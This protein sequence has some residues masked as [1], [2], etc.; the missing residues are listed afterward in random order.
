MYGVRLPF[1]VYPSTSQLEGDIL[2]AKQDYAGAFASYDK[3]NQTELASPASFFSAAKAKELS[4]AAPEE[5]IAL[6]DSCIAR[7]QTPITFRFGSLPVGT[8][9][10]YMNV[11][12]YRLALGR[13]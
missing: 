6:L 4:K 3:V 13:L 12:K 10:M 5:V 7:C 8:C 1:R 11:E 9:Q 2:F